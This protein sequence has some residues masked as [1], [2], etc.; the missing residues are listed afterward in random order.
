MPDPTNTAR[1]QR[2]RDRQAGR[3]AAAVRVGCQ[4]CGITH[5]GARGQLCS[6]CWQSLTPEG[7]ADRAA[8]VAKARARAKAKV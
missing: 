5:T 8:R 6:R 4:A 7:R 3:L 2:W 1:Q